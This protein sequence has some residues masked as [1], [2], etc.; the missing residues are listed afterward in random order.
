[1]HFTLIRLAKV[2]R[3]QAAIGQWRCGT[4]SLALMG[5]HWHTHSGKVC[6]SMT[7]KVTLKEPSTQQSYFEGHLPE[8]WPKTWITLHHKLNIH[9]HKHNFMKQYIPLIHMHSGRFYSI[10]T[11]THKVM[12]QSTA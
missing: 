7:R 10:L 6:C 2:K 11:M 9:T 12:S 4:P 3:K 8:Q 1:M 5:V